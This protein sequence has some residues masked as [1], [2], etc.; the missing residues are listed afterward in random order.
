M[1]PT[2]KIL[3]LSM[4][5]TV[6]MVI[7][8]VAGISSR[9]QAHSMGYRIVEKKTVPVVT[10]YYSGGKAVSYAEVTVWSPANNSIEFQNGR[11]DKNGV[12]IFN[13]DI[14]GIWRIEVDDGLGHRV[15]AEYEVYSPSNKG[16]RPSK[17]PSSL[18][19]SAVL[20]VSLIFNIAGMVRVIAKINRHRLD[21]TP[22]INSK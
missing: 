14:G 4:L 17:E 9:A 21:A 18:L 5:L 2:R 16:L 12:F 11:T 13:P 10:F 3:L 15:A 22:R 1:S 19:L 8:I 20:G 7:M 6:V